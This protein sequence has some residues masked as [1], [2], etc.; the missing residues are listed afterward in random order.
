MSAEGVVGKDTGSE[1]QRAMQPKEACL[2]PH[3]SCAPGLETR[4][5]HDNNIS[6]D[7]NNS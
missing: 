2:S 3:V 6:D 4:E 1:K 5:D 7:D